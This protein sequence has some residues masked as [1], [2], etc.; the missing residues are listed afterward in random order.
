L[1]AIWADFGTVLGDF[2]RKHLATLFADLVSQ[3]QNL[4]NI[5]Q[6][7]ENYFR[8]FLDSTWRLRKQFMLMSAESI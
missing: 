6:K 4:K 1:G 3:W 8:I 2:L 5:S 7:R